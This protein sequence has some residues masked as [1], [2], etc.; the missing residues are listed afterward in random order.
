MND[1]L[2]HRHWEAQGGGQCN[3]TWQEAEDQK[4]PL[5]QGQH[6]TSHSGVKNLFVLLKG[7]TFLKHV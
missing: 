7:D 6:E 1:S 2:H 4:D 3:E 5:L